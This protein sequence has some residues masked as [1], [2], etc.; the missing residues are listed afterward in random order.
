MPSD[1]CCCHSLSSRPWRQH[2]IRLWSVV[3]VLYLRSFFSTAAED[4]PQSFEGTLTIMSSDLPDSPAPWAYDSNSENSLVYL[5]HQPKIFTLFELEMPS[6]VV[7][8]TLNSGER[9]VVTG[10]LTSSDSI[11][12]DTIEAALPETV[13]MARSVAPSAPTAMSTTAAVAAAAAADAAATVA[14]AAAVA[15]TFAMQ[16]PVAALTS[17]SSSST[18]SDGPTKPALAAALAAAL[19]YTR[20]VTDVPVLF[21]ILSIC[22]YPAATTKQELERTVFA[23]PGSASLTLESYYYECSRGKASMSRS[24]S[25]V[26]GPIHVP[27]SFNG[28]YRFSASSCTYRDAWG[29]QTFAQQYLTLN[30]SLD[31]SRYRHRVAV[32]PRYFTNDAGCPWI[33]LGTLGPVE[34]GADGS[35]I[36]SMAWVQGESSGDVMAFM[37]ELGHN[38]YLHH[39][40]GSNGCEYCDW[41]S[42]MGGCCAVR[43]HNAPH[44]WQLG[45]GTPLAVLTSATLPVGVFLYFSLPS[46]TAADAHILWLQPDW[47]T[48]GRR[49]QDLPVSYYI[50]YRIDSGRYDAD[51]PESFLYATNVYYWNGP[52]Q[53]SV[54]RTRHVASVF[55]GEEYRCTKER[56]VVRQLAHAVGSG[57]VGLCRYSEE[58]ETSCRDGLDND[59]DGLVDSAD[60]DCS[61]PSPPRSPPPSPPHPRPPPGDFYPGLGDAPP[62]YEE[63]S[64]ELLP[65]SKPRPPH[66]TSPP[67]P[68]PRPSPPP[69]PLP[70]PKP[71]PPPP[72]KSPPRIGVLSRPPPLKPPPAA[73]HPRSPPPSSPSPPPSPPPS[74]QPPPPPGLP[75]PPRPPKSKPPPPSPAPYHPPNPDPPSPKPSASPAVKNEPPPP[76]PPSPNPPRRPGSPPP[77]PI[78]PSPRPPKKKSP[79]P[80]PPSPPPPLRPSPSTPPPAAGSRRRPPPP[81]VK[82]SGI[83]TRR[84][85]LAFQLERSELL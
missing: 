35:Y 3:M 7:H 6:T 74:P 15:A 78:P 2:A 13:V 46:Q 79:P 9:V 50:S 40:N 29:W 77:S 23:G 24:N 32:L 37:H 21:I 26:V 36:S 53:T 73:K 19:T 30:A 14:R 48:S 80:P 67:P 70:P 38:L 51:I 84:R 49:D 4:G 61:S 34:K 39:A 85:R 42:V 31:I 57:R 17:S 5:L 52:S 81:A 11:R 76:R 12:V 82:I 55:T 8:G 43:C 25:M 66:P 54:L 33:G 72:M 83:Q 27:C 56:W 63:D 22:D 44:N 75:I 41:S 60:P 65:P 45:W 59:C 20:I 28:S 58:R 71:K 47:T 69:S 62:G 68:P 64:K 1:G 18:V 10:W 16:V